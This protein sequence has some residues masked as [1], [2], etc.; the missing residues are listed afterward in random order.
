MRNTIAD[1]LTVPEAA[2]QR[3]SIR[4]YEPVPVPREDLD[5]ILDV[6]RRAPSAFNVQPWRFVVVQ[7]P[8]VREQLAAAAFNQRQVTSAPAVIVLYTDGLMPPEDAK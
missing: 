3:R 7:T 2:K 6:V 1:V 5:A 4:A 8:E